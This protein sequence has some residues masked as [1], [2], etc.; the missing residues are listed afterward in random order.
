MSGH[1]IS[2]E[3]VIAP[4]CDGNSRMSLIIFGF[5]I[6]TVAEH[7]SHAVQGI[8]K[9]ILIAHFSLSILSK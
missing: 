2:L 1:F 5:I 4:P 7:T 3:Y 8:V 6:L 9:S